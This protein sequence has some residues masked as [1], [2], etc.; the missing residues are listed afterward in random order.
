MVT[1]NAEKETRYT[2]EIAVLLD[3]SAIMEETTYN[4]IKMI[5]E[6][7]ERDGAFGSMKLTLFSHFNIVSVKLS[8]GFN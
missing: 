3:R 6:S 5:G 8:F 7:G 2:L 4:W 1:A